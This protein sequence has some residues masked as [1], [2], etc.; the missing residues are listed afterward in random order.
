ML[1][2][3]LPMILLSLFTTPENAAAIEGDLLEQARIRGRWW[4][5]A[6]LLHTSFALFMQSLLREPL[7]VF[8]LSFGVYELMAKVHFYAILPFRRYLQYSLD[9]P[10]TVLAF[11]TRAVW[12]LFACWVGAALVRFLPRFGI[13]VVIGTGGLVLARLLVLQEQ[14]LSMVEVLLIVLL[15]MMVGGILAR[16]RDPGLRQAGVRIS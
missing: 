5:W 14:G 8:L 13:H 12:L 7:P 4:F 6:H 3:S 16:R 15:P 2:T 10:A 11:G 9:F 1:D